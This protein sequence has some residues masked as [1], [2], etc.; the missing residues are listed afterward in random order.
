MWS[1]CT[2]YVCSIF[3]LFTGWFPDPWKDKI[4]LKQ[5]TSKK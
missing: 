2:E 4:F 5:T 1:R 3:T